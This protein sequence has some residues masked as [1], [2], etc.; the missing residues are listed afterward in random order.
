MKW[1]KF[2]QYIK[3]LFNLKMFLIKH[4]ELRCWAEVILSEA[5]SEQDTLFVEYEST[6]TNLKVLIYKYVFMVTVVQV[7]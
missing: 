7:E 3:S 4:G 6:S 1:L 2:L 5:V